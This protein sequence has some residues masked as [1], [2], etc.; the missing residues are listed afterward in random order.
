MP[1][2]DWRRWT[3][4]APLLVEEGGDIPAAHT[5]E[6]QGEDSPHNGSHFL[7]NDD[8]IFLRGVYLVAV[9]R[10]AA[11][12]LSLPLLIPLDAL[13]FLGDI[14]GIHVVH[15]GTKG[16]YIVGGRVYSSVDAVQQRDV[17]HPVLGEV[18]LHVVAGQNVVLAQPGEVLGDDHVDLL[19]LDAS[20]HP[21]EGRAV[22]IR[23]APAVIYI[24]I[25]DA[26]PVLLYKLPQQGFLVLDTLGWSFALILL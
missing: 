6:G 15:D 24:G 21:L 7:I 11:D 2:A 22:K 26:Q 13:D 10:L 5:G 18:P 19:G 17:P 16:R 20:D 8:L 25:V 23:A 3:E 9:H 12:K 1:P 14:L 4:W